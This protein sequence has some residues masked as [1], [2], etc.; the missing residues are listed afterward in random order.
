MLALWDM[1]EERLHDEDIVSAWKEL[2]SCKT[3]GCWSSRSMVLHST[4]HS[5]GQRLA[6]LVLGG[7]GQGYG[8]VDLYTS[9]VNGM[10]LCVYARCAGYGPYTSYAVT[11][12][13]CLPF[14][15]KQQ[16]SL[17]ITTD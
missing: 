10:R 8:Q 7:G 12:L 4:Q 3:S 17:F 5:E 1:H 13:V 16:P 2:V 14:P 11:R 6:V 9:Q 15:A